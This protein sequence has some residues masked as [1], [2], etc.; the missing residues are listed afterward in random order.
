MTIEAL[1]DS[2][3]VVSL[4]NG[5]D[6]SMLPRVRAL[7]EA[8]EGIR[9]PAVLDVVPAFS[10]VAVYY[11]PV[12]FGGYAAKP[13]EN[14]CRFIRECA[15]GEGRGAAPPPIPATV[16][17]PVCYGG[18]FGPDLAAVAAHCGLTAEDV[19][20]RHSRAEYAVH[21]IGFV[22]GF[23]YLVGLPAELQMARRATPR[24]S[25]PAGSVGIGGAQTGVYP[26]A[27]PGGWQ[28]IGRSPIQFF[29]PD[30]SPPSLLLAGDRVR[31]RAISREEF[32]RVER[33]ADGRR[34]Q[35]AEAGASMGRQPLQGARGDAPLLVNSVKELTSKGAPP[36]LDP[37]F[38][39][40]RPG[41]LTM[42]QDLGRT[43]YRA[44]GVPLS[45]AMD[46]P[47]L[48]SANAL[49]GNP[50]GAAGL[51]ITLVGPELEFRQEALIAVEGAEFEGI[52]PGVAKW[53]CP[54]ERLTFGPCLRGCR[55]Y[56]AVAGGVDVPAVLG[57][58]STY[59][60]GG[61][62]GFRGRAL[63][64]GDRVARGQVVHCTH[65]RRMG[66]MYNLTL[67]TTVRAIRGAHFDEFGD[68]LFGVPFTLSQASDRMGLRMEGPVLRRK[69]GGELVSGAVAP[70][71][72]QV[73]PDGR[74]IVLAAD[75]Q[76]IG[77]YP[78][79]AHVI[80]ADLPILAQLKPGDCVTF[81][82]ISLAD[83]H[84]GLVNR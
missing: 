73:P 30:R 6:S 62:G 2:A 37:V 8:I 55:A 63:R 48:C 70:G 26:M 46:A 27:T 3:V 34:A 16:E 45:G 32:D 58:R 64:A 13:F 83:A 23:P 57:S 38:E 29:S 47:A 68:S 60:R 24:L 36:C 65:A 54:G 52:K 39:V 53:M 51:E 81:T 72:V 69:G 19:S 22:P 40:I 10:A 74:P 1:G 44:S 67:S 31:F 50:V 43:G 79:A 41:L 77:G 17:I 9:A 4:G 71:T 5:I 11:D 59:Q 15:S 20:L 12:G 61:F 21:A 25:V 18:E 56:L 33:G 35:A 78:K 75:A 76:T 82:E 14:V 80:S 7:A 66:T 49:V 28:L 84:A 42:V